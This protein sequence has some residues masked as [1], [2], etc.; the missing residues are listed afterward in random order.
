MI[1][2]GHDLLLLLQAIRSA[3]SKPPRPA[4]Q[5]FD[6]VFA[7]EKMLGTRGRYVWETWTQDDIERQ[8]TAQ[9]AA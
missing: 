1:G 6:R 4:H 5:Q 3:P 2:V 9:D 8:R 7:L